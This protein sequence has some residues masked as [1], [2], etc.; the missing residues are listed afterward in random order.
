MVDVDPVGGERRAPL[1]EPGD[2]RVAVG[3]AVADLHFEHG[4]SHSSRVKGGAVERAL[5]L[6]ATI[7]CDDGNGERTH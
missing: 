7:G 5:D 1:H 6:P 4:E 2:D 3:G